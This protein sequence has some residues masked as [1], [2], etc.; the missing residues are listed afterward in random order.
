MSYERH[1]FTPDPSSNLSYAAKPG[2]TPPSAASSSPNPSQ[3]TPTGEGL[4][5]SV[6][7]DVASTP[8]YFR[9]LL[10][11]VPARYAVRPIKEFFNKLSSPWIDQHV[12]GVS[13][14]MEPV[15]NYVENAASPADAAK[16]TKAARLYDSKI[17]TEALNDWAGNSLNRDAGL[18]DLKRATREGALDARYDTLL[19]VGSTAITLAYAQRVKTDIMHVY[20]E[21]VG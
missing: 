9:M 14:K 15:L 1:D 7:R 4:H 5:T 8:A 3:P 21:T 12:L 18:K 19:G 2:M 11:A 10:A 6:T 17:T 13:K 20:A 16:A